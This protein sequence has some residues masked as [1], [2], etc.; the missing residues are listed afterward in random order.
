MFNTASEKEEMNYILNVKALRLLKDE[1]DKNYAIIKVSNPENKSFGILIRDFSKK[2]KEFNNYLKELKK[3]R[4]S[5][6]VDVKDLEIYKEKRFDY[7]S[8]NMKDVQWVSLEYIEDFENDKEKLY[9]GTLLEE[10]GVMPGKIEDRF[11][12][13]DSRQHILLT[14]SP[15]SGKGVSYIVPTILKTWKES[16]FVFDVSGENYHLTSG[17]RK[18]KFD[19]NILYF[20]PKS[21]NSCPYNSLAEVR[22]LSEH[23]AE[24]VRTIAD[25]IKI[26]EQ[27]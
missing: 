20:V 14:M 6:E 26:I 21:K 19:N 10:N 4:A 3:H 1:L 8:N 2:T 25:S 15:R 13:D 16:L 7:F 12:I 27:M 18:E 9:T 23:E 22:I 17:A 11:L 5:R 24:D